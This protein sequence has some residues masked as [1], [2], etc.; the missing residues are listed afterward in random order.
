MNISFHHIFS[1]LILL[2]GAYAKIMMKTNYYMMKVLH[3]KISLTL[4]SST[5][6]TLC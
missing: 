6:P 4:F 3:E 1:Q 2:Q 5:L